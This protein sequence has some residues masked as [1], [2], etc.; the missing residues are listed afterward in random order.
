MR[1][2]IRDCNAANSGDAKPGP[3]DMAPMDR[4]KARLKAQYASLPV[5]MHLVTTSGRRLDPKISPKAAHFRV[6]RVAKA[7]NMPMSLRASSSIAKAPAWIARS[8]A[9]Q[10]AGAILGV[11]IAPQSVDPKERASS[12]R[13]R[14]SRENLN[15]GLRQRCFSRLA[16]RE[17]PRAG[18][19]RSFIGAAPGAG[20][21][22]ERLQTA[23]AKLKE[24]VDVVVGVAETHG[25][26]ERVALLEGLEVIPRKPMNYVNRMLSEFD[27]DAAIKRHP[28]LMLVDE[29]AHT[30]ARGSR[31][32]KRSLHV[33]EPCSA[34]TLHG[35]TAGSNRAHRSGTAFTLALPLP[36]PGRERD[37][38]A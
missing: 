25:R 19:L 38:A 17:Q 23:R 28:N 30:N 3:I 24:G 34:G 18:E 6:T 7:C 1:P 31:H 29:L 15:G 22:C 2:P 4:V 16:R 10:R 14:C 35:A 37:T 33:E 27:V 5:P 21:T 36:A 20:R 12:P 11:W 8:T 32:P 13:D 26:R 9:G